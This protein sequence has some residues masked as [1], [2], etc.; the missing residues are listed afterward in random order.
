MKL[1]SSLKH[2]TRTLCVWK[3]EHH[4]TAYLDASGYWVKPPDVF[5]LRINTSSLFLP[6]L[7]SAKCWG[8][9]L[10]NISLCI[11][12]M[13]AAALPQALQGMITSQGEQLS[14]SMEWLL[15]FS[16]STPPCKFNL[17]HVISFSSYLAHVWTSRKPCVHAQ[18]MQTQTNTQKKTVRRRTGRQSVWGQDAS[19]VVH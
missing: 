13:W 11:K 8:E 15:I 19:C 9:W 4:R 1:N 5:V 17:V 16:L 10:C 7:V 18:H 3:P 6:T 12:C 2:F 14:N